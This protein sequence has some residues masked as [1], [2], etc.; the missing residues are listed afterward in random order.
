MRLGISGTLLPDDVRDLTLKT[1]RTLRSWGYTGVFTRLRRERSAC[2]TVSDADCRRF[3]DILGDAGLDHVHG[4]R[5]LAKP[6]SSQS[7]RLGNAAFRCSAPGYG[8]PPGWA[9]PASTPAP[10]A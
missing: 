1:A 7:L 5:L 2:S 8:W 6:G 10:A 3:R 4:H 9:R